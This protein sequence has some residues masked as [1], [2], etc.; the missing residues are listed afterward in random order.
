MTSTLN[1][2][3]NLLLNMS[4]PEM[5]ESLILKTDSSI[6]FLTNIMNKYF[7]YTS[8]ISLH[9]ENEMVNRQLTVRHILIL[10]QKILTFFNYIRTL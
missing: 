8:P 5:S 6:K 3:H 7:A 4:K 1:E 2:F 10:F 9:L